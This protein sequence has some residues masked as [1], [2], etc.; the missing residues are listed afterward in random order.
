[1]LP[2]DAPMPP[3]AATVWERVGN[4]F[5]STA[6][7]NPACASCNE[8]RMPEPPAPTTMAS[9][10]RTGGVTA[11]AS[12]NAPRGRCLAEDP[13][14]S[15]APPEQVDE[16]DGV[17]EEGQG[18][19]RFEGQPQRGRLQIIHPD[20]AHAHPGVPQQREPEQQRGDAERAVG[21]QRLPQRVVDAALVPGDPQP[22][23]RVEHHDQRRDAL[24]EPVLEPVVRTDDDAPHHSRTPTKTASARLTTSTT[25]LDCRAGLSS[26]P[27]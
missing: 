14:R 7:D 13:A 6:T 11:L 17:G 19:Q 9:N 16:P 12:G 10:L 3:C 27:W 25:T 8:A 18:S 24:H 23:Q 22:E 2:S 1:M 26:M 5:D 4:T 15:P 21:E 20:V